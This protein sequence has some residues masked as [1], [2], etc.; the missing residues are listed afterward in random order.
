[1][2]LRSA[3]IN[4]LLSD[5]EGVARGSSNRFQVRAQPEH[6]LGDGEARA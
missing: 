6:R 4:L 3:E 1:L 2:L 5:F